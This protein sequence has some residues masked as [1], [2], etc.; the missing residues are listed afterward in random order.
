[1]LLFLLHMAEVCHCER[2][3]YI[4]ACRFKLGDYLEMGAMQYCDHFVKNSHPLNHT[5]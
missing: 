4:T 5:G 1:M 2:L 3:S